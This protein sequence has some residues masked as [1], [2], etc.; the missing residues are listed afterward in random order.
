MGDGQDMDRGT[1]IDPEGIRCIAYGLLFEQ[2]SSVVHHSEQVS[3][4]LQEERHFLIQ[5]CNPTAQVKLR[6]QCW[7]EIQP[8]FPAKGFQS[9]FR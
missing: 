6:E 3:H 8:A 2:R 4:F 1:Q 7:R 5:N 9:H